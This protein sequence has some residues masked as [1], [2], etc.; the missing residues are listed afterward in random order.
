MTCA[1]SSAH[2]AENCGVYFSGKMAK[3]AIDLK[4]RPMKVGII[5]AMESEFNAISAL[6][7]GQT[8]GMI[9]GNEIM[10]SR[11]GIGKVNAAVKTYELIESFHPDCIISTGVAG[12]AGLEVEPLD[13]VVSKEVVYHDVWCGDGNEYGQVQGLPARYKGNETLC[14]HAL[15]LNTSTRIHGGLICTGDRFIDDP[16]TVG[17]I[18]EHFPEGL[19]VDMESGAIAQVCELRNVPFLS[20]RVISDNPRNSKSFTQYEN[21]WAEL[22]SHSLEV[23]RQFITTLPCTL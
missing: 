14:G 6:L 16:E 12:G 21:F 1:N 17:S 11:S 7:G 2:C 20:F 5:I 9:G 4:K 3:F 18:L 23:I 8:S 15:G 10:L 13:A 19:A 22:S